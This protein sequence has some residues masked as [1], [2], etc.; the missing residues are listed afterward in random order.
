M[1]SED[2]PF[3]RRVR[4]LPA[5]P[6]FEHLKN[7]AKQRLRALRAQ[8]P[9]AQLSRAQLAVAR[10]YGFANWRALKAHVDEITRGRVFAS[11]R[12]GDVEAVRRAF[13]GGFDPSFTDDDGRTIHQIGK[14]SGNEAIELLARDF[15]ARS[16]RPAA[17]EQAV[18]AIL[19]A[20]EKGRA[21]DLG[22]LLDT[23][24]DLIDARGANFWG[25][26]ALH[27]AAWRNRAD[28]VRLLLE[29]G[30]DVRIRDYGDSAY[31]LH[32]AAYAADLEIVQLLVQA[33]SDVVGEG[34][35]HQVGVLGWATCF[36]RVR[37]DVAAYLLACGASSNL[38]SAIALDREDD[39]RGLI[40]R[41]PSLVS[42]RMSRNEHHRTPLHHAAAKSRLRM[43]RLLLDLGADPNASD[44]VGMTPLTSASQEHA[45]P[46]IVAMLLAAGATLDFMT[47]LYLERYEIIETLLQDDPSC[48]GPDGR[49]TIALHLSV[50][51]KNAVAVRW[52]IAHGVD[53][54]SKRKLWDCNHT[55]LHMTAESG[56]IEIARMLLDA[57]A[58]PNIRD[59]K[60]DATVL[61]WAEFCEQP[62]VAELVRERGGRV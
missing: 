30:A 40:A 7:E 11:A 33:D 45:D 28:C 15:Q 8:E 47:A 62:Q 57:G 50:S 1:N 54:N 53:V 59:D 49:D 51:K 19:D 61:A 48:I 60:Y 46:A 3:A 58:D 31:P 37:E 29:R 14:V 6:N 36:A 20:A 13:E 18:N 21:D 35:D 56:A 10:D 16:N 38:W 24:P 41:D 25:R 23:R 22:R 39:V 4:A 42:A 43:V 34:D 52:L 26:T 9:R 5:R 12:A 32:F 44:A 27:M 2:A 17:V 55:A